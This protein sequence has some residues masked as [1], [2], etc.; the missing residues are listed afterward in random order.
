M[1]QQILQTANNRLV[2]NGPGI[3]NYVFFGAI[4]L[5]GCIFGFAVL[6]MLPDP[7][8]GWETAEAFIALGIMVMLLVVPLAAR[9]RGLIDVR[10]QTL[11]MAILL[12]SFLLI[13]E[14]VFSRRNAI[15]AAYQGSFQPA[16]YAETMI[17]VVCFAVLL[18]ITFRM[19]GY[20]GRLIAPSFRWL[21][22][23]ALFSMASAAYSPA[24]AFAFAWGFKLVL[25]VLLLRVILDEIESVDDLRWFLRAV[26][27]SFTILAVLC[28]A[29][30][31]SNPNPW[32][33]GAHDRGHIAHWRIGHC[34]YTLT[35]GPNLLHRGAS[36]E[37]PHP[38]GI[39]LLRHAYRL[40]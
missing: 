11:A 25:V 34:R 5:V 1:Q 8:I 35:A 22:L 32:G 15:G 30:F 21:F 28:F 6:A 14:R 31:I 4:A 39:R 10:Q 23:L 9:S 16:A 38:R 17:W 24:K 37:V 2:V 27:W 12:F 29:Q 7:M 13:A 18:L 40:R 20:L 26:L 33:G 3:R 36:A 19:P